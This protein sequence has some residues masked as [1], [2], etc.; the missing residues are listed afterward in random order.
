MLE[1]GTLRI[2]TAL[3]ESAGIE[4]HLLRIL[5]AMDGFA[6]AHLVIDAI[7]A[8]RRMGSPQAAFDFL[9]R[10]LTTCKERGITCFYTCQAAQ[11]GH[12]AQISGIG[13][14]SLMDTIIGLRYRGGRER[15]DRR[16]LVVKSRGS[17]HS[18]AYHGMVITGQGIELSRPRTETGEDPRGGTP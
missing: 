10:V 13:I 7:S 17:D 15:L 14:E 12:A 8:C 4:Q 5:E 6:P 1:A 18:M 16:L 11:G 2:M 9:V 3:P